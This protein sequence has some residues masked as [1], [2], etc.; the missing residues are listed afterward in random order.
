MLKF[1]R[2]SEFHC[3]CQCPYDGHTSSDTNNPMRPDLGCDC[4]NCRELTETF[5]Q[6]NCNSGDGKNGWHFTK[7]N[8][9]S[10]LEEWMYS[11]E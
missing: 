8:F 11:P 6:D 9:F 7:D 5:F 10:G 2:V 3:T 1:N 4:H